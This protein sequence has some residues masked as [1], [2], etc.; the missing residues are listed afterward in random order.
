MFSLFF[1][2]VHFCGISG[3][4]L[5]NGD[6]FPSAKDNKVRPDE[7]SVCTCHN[8]TSL[9]LKQTCPVLDC[10]PQNQHI[11]K[12]ECCPECN[13]TTEYAIS[14]CT[15]KEKTYQVSSA[16]VV[17]IITINNSLLLFFHIIPIIK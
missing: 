11:K 12:G 5:M 14:E 7:C 17:L 9:C 1:S 15:Y 10:L 4:C 6:Y 3:G 8:E 13:S 2:L 16:V